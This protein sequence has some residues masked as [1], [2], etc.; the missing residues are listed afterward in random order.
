M[1]GPFVHIHLPVNTV[2][3]MIAAIKALEDRN[4]LVGVPEEKT[5]RSDGAATNALLTYLNDKGSPAR[6]I[7]AM[8]FMEG[9]IEDTGDRL[10]KGLALGANQAIGGDKAAVERTLTQVGLIAVS[11][12]RNRI[13]SGSY[14]PLKPATIRARQRRGRTGTKRFQDTGQARN[15]ITFVLRSKGK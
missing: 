4:V 9:G 7:P 5:D 3:E 2:P 8:N 6:G 14:P 13:D 10:E 1:N 15:S 11:G 12:I